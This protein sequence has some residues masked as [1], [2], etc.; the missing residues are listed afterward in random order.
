MN[1]VRPRGA[2][3]GALRRIMLPQVLF[4]GVTL[5]SAAAA[6]IAHGD[7]LPR[8][9]Y[10]SLAIVALAT[11][12]AVLLSLRFGLKVPASW[13]VAFPL[14]DLGVWAALRDGFVQAF[15]PGAFAVIFPLTWLAFLFA[16]RFLWVA[17]ATL[18]FA[19]VYPLL[20]QPSADRA[21][22]VSAL[23]FP[24]FMMIFAC[25]IAV[26]S[27]QFWR[28]QEGWGRAADR[29][30]DLTREHSQ[31]AS[32]LDTVLNAAS[33]G[34]I[35]FDSRG[36]AVSVSQEARRLQ[37]AFT[38]HE[39][40]P[41][42][43]AGRFADGSPIPPADEFIAR[44]R[45]GE[46]EAG[47]T[48][49]LSGA[50][51]DLAIRFSAH[52]VISSDGRLMG[53]VMITHDVTELTAAVQARETFLRTV[54]HELRTPLTVILARAELLADIPEAATAAET[55][56]RASE[57]QLAVI[58]QLLA[59]SRSHRPGASTRIELASL[60]RKVVA[61]VKRTAPATDRSIR[62][63]TAQSDVAVWG[64]PED[65]GKILSALLANACQYSAPGTTVE[66]TLS[67]TAVAAVVDVDD[68]GVGMTVA[69]RSQAFDAFYRTE[70]SHKQA[71]PGVGLGLTLALQIAQANGGTLTLLPAPSGRG[72]R[73][74]LTLT[75][76][77]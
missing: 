59:A 15:T 73:A 3:M 68:S 32:T 6:V 67:A 63:D 30:G 33:D 75:R 34:I 69:E 57:K 51:G 65:I 50:D 2:N 53:H 56:I 11:L 60:I 52:P 58:K 62:F 13:F 74:R 8:A 70:Y 29:V 16:M 17:A 43:F 39:A 4:F 26:I 31:T 12:G 66:M 42:I 27:R 21:S 24:V 14:I 9:F 36:V 47:T 40:G 18:T 77:D 10:A 49:H 28:A 5:S 44:M 25:G 38:M 55:I 22:I 1:L 54:G 48:A 71:I 7:L 46:F 20:T 35:I 76:R 41:A 19:G 23:A 72:T 64:D 37:T 61:D 45:A